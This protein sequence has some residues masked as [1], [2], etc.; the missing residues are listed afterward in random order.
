M[1]LGPIEPGSVP[2]ILEHS[3]DVVVVLKAHDATSRAD[4]E[5]ALTELVPRYSS[6]THL[7]YA[8]GTH[9]VGQRLL[10][11]V[12]SSQPQ[13]IAHRF[14]IIWGQPVG[15]H[16]EA[17]AAELADA[18][19]DPRASAA[20]LLGTWVAL[21]P[22]ESGLRLLNGADLVHTWTTAS[23]PFGTAFAT[24]GLAAL[25]ACGL[26]AR[27]AVDHVAD[28]VH[29]EY[30]LG[31]GSLLEGTRSLHEASCVDLVDRTT[32]TDDCTEWSY[33][34]QVQRYADLP[35][36]SAQ[37][38]RATLTS[39]LART[40]LLPGTSLALTAGRDSTLLASCLHDAG[41]VVPSLTLGTRADPDV[42]GAAACAAAWRSAHSHLAPSGNGS[43]S[44]ARAIQH[45]S[46]TEGMQTARIT[47]GP[48]LPWPCSAKSVLITGSGGEIARRFYYA[49]SQ[50]TTN[51]TIDELLDHMMGSFDSCVSGPARDTFRQRLQT[52]LGHYASFGARGAGQLDLLYS[53][54]RMATWLRRALPRPDLYSVH[55]SYLSPAVERQLLAAA[56]QSSD[57]LSFFD[58]AL[59]LSPLNLHVVATQAA[60]KALTSKRARLHPR[61][62]SAAARIMGRKDQQ[63]PLAQLIHRLATSPVLEATLGISWVGSVTQRAARDPAARRQAWNALAVAALESNLEGE[64]ADIA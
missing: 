50:L 24:Q 43:F 61:R 44:F 56:C 29:L 36:A 13:S 10:I 33:L 23:G 49:R 11:A 45:S 38:L 39:E 27:I 26:R 19:K 42:I 30:V 54:G 46:W 7:S 63:D 18:V 21:A 31:R 62:A 5:L 58:R 3:S 2:C 20:L 22:T 15:K 59:A 34:P 32:G 4:A 60:Q 64:S 6:S 16:G 40:A 1:D 52:E 12:L 28:F 25:T 47:A 37:A 55:P 41:L 57:A 51:S 48:P 53:R 17:S 14:P 35:P 8:L 9:Q